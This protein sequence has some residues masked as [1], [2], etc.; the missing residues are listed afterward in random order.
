[1][2]QLI[3]QLKKYNQPEAVQAP[4]SVGPPMQRQSPGAPMAGQPADLLYRVG[5]ARKAGGMKAAA[6]VKQRARQE[7]QDATFVAIPRP[8]CGLCL[9]GRDSGALIHDLR[10]PLN[11]LP[12]R[13]AERIQQRREHVRCAEGAGGLYYAI[14]AADAAG[15][16][17]GAEAEC[18]AE[19]A[20]EKRSKSVDVGYP[21]GGGPGQLAAVADHGSAAVVWVFESSG[22]ALKPSPPTP[23]PAAGEGSTPAVV[24]ALQSILSKTGYQIGTPSSLGGGAGSR[25][26]YEGGLQGGDPN[27]NALPPGLTG[28]LGTLKSMQGTDRPEF[29]GGNDIDLLK[30]A[31]PIWDTIVRGNEVQN[32]TDAESKRLAATLKIDNLQAQEI[33][34]RIKDGATTGDILKTELA[35][36]QITNSMIKAIDAATI[37]AKKAEA[38]SSLAAAAEHGASTHATNAKLPYEISNLQKLR[39]GERNTKRAL[40]LQLNDG[41]DVTSV[42]GATTP[43]TATVA[44]AIT[45]HDAI[46]LAKGGRRLPNHHAVVVGSVTTTKRAYNDRTRFVNKQAGRLV[47]PL[48]P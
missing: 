9:R 30:T 40:N 17:G 42:S 43:A 8:R 20:S 44:D 2:Q 47:Y 41:S 10:H 11:Q 37:A 35:G 24:P 26:H 4:A 33:R 28:I 1:M 5:G 12:C 39:A 13:R 23:L 27:P 25:P 38:T 32:N 36:K 15:P 46:S 18:A 48:I 3:A 14:G 45:P 16:G 31:A 34:Q 22:A 6:T 7:E 29:G 19:R 21:A